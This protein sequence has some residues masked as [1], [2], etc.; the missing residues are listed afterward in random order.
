MGYGVTWWEIIHVWFPDALGVAGIYQGGKTIDE[1]SDL[2]KEW[3]KKKIIKQKAEGKERPKFIV[4]WDEHG[5]PLR[6]VLLNKNGEED[7]SEN[8]DARKKTPP[9]DLED[10]EG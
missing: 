6:K 4:L 5:E 9:D 7:N 10:F 1:V 2:V 8:S 3:A